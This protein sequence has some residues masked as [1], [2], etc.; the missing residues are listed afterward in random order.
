TYEF[1][2]WDVNPPVLESGA[3]ELGKFVDG[4]IKIPGQTASHTFEATA[5]QTI[6]FHVESVSEGTY[7]NLIG[8]DGRTQVFSVYN[9]D[10]GPVTLEQAGTYTLVA[11]PDG[12]NKP[13]YEFIV[14]DVNPSAVEGGA[15]EF[16]KFVDGEIKIPGQT[17]SHTFEATAGQTIYFHMESASEG[18]YFNLMAPDKHTQVFSVYNSDQGPVTLEQAGT[19]TLVVD[20]DGANKPKVE[21]G[22]IEFGKFVDGEIKI[23]GQTA[24]HTFEATA[25][26][27]IYFHM[28]SSSEGT[29]FNLMA[30]DK[31][32]QVFS[33]YNSDQGPVMLEQAGTYTLVVDP[34][35]PNKPKYEFDIWDVNPPVL[36]GGALE[37]GKFVDGEI[38]IPGQTASYTFEATAGQT[39]NFHVESTTEGTYFNLMAPDGH[40]P[41]FSVYN[42]DQGPVT[43]DQAGTYT[44][45]VDPDGPNKPKYEFVIN[46]QN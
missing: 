22:A 43:L 7:F 23:P 38:K 1:V 45:V 24:S 39:I 17:A 29:Y 12:A 9:S 28:E 5:G 10:Q 3:L 2:I 19:Y 36:E 31:H 33:V 40:T 37:L 26:Q 8:P 15:I 41:V 20:P 11:D 34:D 27:T 21:G 18:T 42:S 44:L 4:E 30:P 13:K 6:Y 32:T 25:G 16:G 35:G 14:W 46:P